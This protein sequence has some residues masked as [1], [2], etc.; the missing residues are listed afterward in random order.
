MKRWNNSEHLISPCFVHVVF[1]FYCFR[2]HHLEGEIASVAPHL[3]EDQ[4][5]GMSHYQEVFSQEQQNQQELSQQHLQQFTSDVEV[6]SNFLM[7]VSPFHF[8][9][10]YA[11]LLLLS[12]LNSFYRQVFK[13]MAVTSYI[14]LL[15]KSV[16]KAHIFYL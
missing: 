15:M 7:R 4:E 10:K 3:K 13:I 6:I 11:L 16:F 14:I 9:D 12:L 1:C 5:D 8:I 2:T